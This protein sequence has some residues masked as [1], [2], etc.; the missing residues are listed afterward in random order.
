MGT[1]THRAYARALETLDARGFGIKPDLS[2]ISA[3]VEL[4]DHP[5]LRFPT[6][7]LAG[8]NGKS[9]TARMIGAVLAA[10]G[11]DT[12]VYTSP[13]LQSVRER[14]A[15]IGM[16]EDEVEAEYISQ[17]DFARL[18]EY[19]TRFIE[20]VEVERGE[21]V[22]YF[23]T[24]TVAA[25]EWMADR[26]VEAGVFETGLGGRWDATNVVSPE[27]CVLTHIDVDHSKMLGDT[28]IENAREKAGIIKP[29]SHVVSGSQQ[30]DVL[31]LLVETAAQQ[32]SSFSLMGK[33]FELS[34][35]EI[36]VGGR[37]IGVTGLHASYKEVFVPLLGA[38]QSR[39]AAVAVAACEAFL[40][41]SLEEDALKAGLN[42]VRSPGRMEVISKH[43]LLILDGAHNPDGASVLGPA[44]LETFGR[45]PSTFVIAI[46]RDK[47]AE[48]IF[49]HLLP[50]ADKLLVT[51]SSSERS[52]DPKRLAEIARG[53]GASVEVV[54][55]IPAALE[56]ALEGAGEDEMVV[57][58]GS[59]EAVGKARDH[60]LGPVE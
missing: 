12:G 7:H 20:I 46:L 41:R 16:L 59:L 17:E 35:D 27:V 11:I 26:S 58:T 19:L 51:T 21:Q 6:V 60:L 32:G 42:S 2:R 15:L 14:F 13:H 48:G 9:S 54:D 43:P 57:F 29:G 50:Y 22:T 47:D 31:E 10:H 52:A 28:P 3:L 55:S 25:F 38:H 44:L 39:N 1:H 4:L 34:S 45:R 53:R 33:D 23:E 49:R 8:T 40:G 56:Q 36:A 30:P 24:T 37:L 18:I 5:E